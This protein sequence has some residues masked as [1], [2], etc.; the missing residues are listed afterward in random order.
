[1]A[2]GDSITAGFGLMGRDV[3]DIFDEYRGLR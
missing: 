2:M 1:M 3:P